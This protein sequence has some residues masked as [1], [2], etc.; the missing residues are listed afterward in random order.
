MINFL[1]GFNKNYI[2]KEYTFNDYKDVINEND[3]LLTKIGKVGY[4]EE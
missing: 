3:D 2:K 4:Y 1:M